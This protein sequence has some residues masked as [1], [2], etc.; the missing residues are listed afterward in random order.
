MT[1][2]NRVVQSA[3]GMLPQ[4]ISVRQADLSLAQVCSLVETSMQIRVYRNSL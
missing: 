1:Q 3:H 4:W 2:K